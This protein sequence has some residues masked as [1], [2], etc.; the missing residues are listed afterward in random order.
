MDL[1]TEHNVDNEHTKSVTSPVYYDE[2]WGSD[3]LFWSLKL[4]LT[5]LESYSVFVVMKEDENR[6]SSYSGSGLLRES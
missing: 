3:D 1:L 5:S 2:L 6:A 4:I